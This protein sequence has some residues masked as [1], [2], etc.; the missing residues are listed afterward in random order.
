[1]PRAAAKEGSV[2]KQPDRTEDAEAPCRQGAMTRH[3]RGMA[4]KSNEVGRDASAS[5]F[6]GLF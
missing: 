2:K 6:I 5:E 3:T 1:M 4:R